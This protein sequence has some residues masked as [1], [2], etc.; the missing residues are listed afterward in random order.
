VYQKVFFFFLRSCSKRN[1]RE[2]EK[3]GARF[4]WGPGAWQ[5]WELLLYDL[6]GNIEEVTGG[7]MV[8]CFFFS[9]PQVIFLR[10]SFQC[11]VC[12]RGRRFDRGAEECPLPYCRWK[13][14]RLSSSNNLLIWGE[15]WGERPVVIGYAGH[16]ARLPSFLGPS[17]AL[18]PF[19]WLMKKPQLLC[20]V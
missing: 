8:F 16:V 1:G 10:C 9:F 19:I 20:Y 4:C 3:C 6:K 5:L 18:S 13:L 2:P 12:A 7:E 15:K 14:P 11:Q 17:I